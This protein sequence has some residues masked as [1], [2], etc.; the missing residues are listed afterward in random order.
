MEI[1]T[2]F[3]TQ[4]AGLSRHDTL[5]GKEYLVVPVVAVKH[6]VL[7]KEYLSAD[8]IEKSV[9]FWNDVPIPVYHPVR[10]GAKISA[11]TLAVIEEDVIGRFYNAFYENES[12]KG[13]MWIDIEKAKSLGGDALEVLTSLEAG[14][15]VEVST[16]YFTTVVMEA[17]KYGEKSYNGSQHAIKPDHLALLPGMTG[18]CSITD[19]CGANR[20]NEAGDLM[21]LNAESLRVQLQDGESINDRR[22]AVQ[23]AI[24]DTWIVD[25][26]ED[27]VVYET[28]EVI[29]GGGYFKAPYTIKDGKVTLGTIT[30]VKREVVYNEKETKE[31]VNMADKAA[32]STGILV[33]IKNLLGVNKMSDREMAVETLRKNGVEIEDTI[34]DTVDEAVLN[35]MV[36]ASTVAE[37]PKVIVPE[38]ITNE[39]NCSDAV[40]INEYL[41]SNGTN[42]EELVAHIKA[43]EDAAAAVKKEYVD[44]LVDNEACTLDKAVI[45]AMDN[46]VLKEMNELYKPGKYVGV[47]LPRS[48]EEEAPLAP[49]VVVNAA[50]KVGE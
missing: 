28:S 16:A 14:E 4:A 5:D 1:K 2:L 23:L 49:S 35:W 9:Q 15:V 41:A 29:A 36:E 25:L 34:L 21:G 44:S 27:V 22:D 17:G 13:E 31:I 43:E 3:K 37:S 33:K 38:V 11:K 47:G 10:N 18:A 8:E 50:N 30:S 42:I 26:Y 48:N 6:G 20:T 46:E 40:T 19:G 32:E 7:N 45:E 24:G 39:S 12:L